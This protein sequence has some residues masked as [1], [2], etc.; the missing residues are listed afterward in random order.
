MPSPYADFF[1]K[2]GLKIIEDSLRQ[3]VGKPRSYLKDDDHYRQHV[4]QPG[5]TALPVTIRL[6]MK[7]QFQVWEQLYLALFEEVID[8]SG[9]EIQLSGEAG[10]RIAE[11]VDRY[12]V[13]GTGATLSP[14]VPLATPVEPEAGAEEAPPEEAEAPAQEETAAEEGPLAP[15]VGI[16][17]GTTYSVIAYV[18]AQGRPCSLLNADGERLTPSVVLFG[19]D[20]TIVGKQAVQGSALEPGRTAVCVKRDMGAKFYRQQINGEFLPPEVISSCILR[21][22][23]ADAERV[24]GPVSQAVITV[25]AYFDE[26]RR[27]ATIDAGKLAGLD[28]LDIINEPTAAAIAYGYQLGYLDASCQLV[29]GQRLRVLVFDLGG[30]TFDV[31]IVEIGKSEFRA[32]ATDGDVY[33]GGRDWDE[34]LVNLAAER[35]RSQFRE[36]PRQNPV[37]A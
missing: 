23:K 13:E 6:L 21:S 28:V 25:P 14:E 31:T 22:L 17:L 33:L 15:P 3:V 4:V 1:K 11:L 19:D 9:D 20:G 24:L 30:G 16:D 35:F 32:L 26:T 2:Q 12:L 8:L 7:N 5:W 10:P 29:K 37:S 27:R 36:D 18:D 34:R